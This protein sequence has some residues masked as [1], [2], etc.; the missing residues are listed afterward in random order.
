MFDQISIVALKTSVR[1]QMC[2]EPIDALLGKN[3]ILK[4]HS[5][6]FNK[7]ISNV[8]VCKHFKSSKC[9][10]SFYLDGKKCDLRC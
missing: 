9:M 8:L 2:R 5:D 3:K 4:F 7:N 1:L 10:Y 6:I